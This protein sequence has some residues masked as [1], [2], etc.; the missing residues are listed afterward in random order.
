MKIALTGATGF[1]GSHILTE[2]VEHGHEVTALVRGD[3]SAKAAEALGATPVQLDLTD[4]AAAVRAFAAADA[5][6]HSASPGDATSAEL[7]SA[8]VD[9]VLEAYAGTGK[10]YAQIGGTWVYGSNP[11]ITEDS[12]FHSPPLVAW[13]EPIEARALEARDVR[14]TVVVASVAYGDG[15][16]GLPGALL[17]S[18]RDESGNLITVGDGRQHW[19]T[20]HVADLAAF[21]RAVIENE[22][23]SGYYIVGDGMNPT[24]TELTQ[25]A[26]VA[27]GAPGAVPGS[28][29]EARARF[30]DWF[31]EVLLLD[32]ATAADKARTDLGWRPTRPSLVEEFRQGSYRH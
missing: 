12:P 31:A 32:Q 21:F 4:T 20:V 15:G 30:G 7:D 22:S 25:A 28:E 5:A 27:V 24:V 1:V 29:Q 8:V 17:G 13:R 19:S 23:A 16:G 14:S 3:G 26:A 2:L 10:A 18:P 9:A 6:V 11:A